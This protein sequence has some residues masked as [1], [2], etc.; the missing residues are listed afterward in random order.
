MKPHV[1]RRLLVVAFGLS[2]LAVGVGAG[3][4]VTYMGGRDFANVNT[5]ADFGS[6]VSFAAT[7][8]MVLA[9]SAAR[10]AGR[11]VAHSAIGVLRQLVGWRRRRDHVGHGAGSGWA[12]HP[13]VQRWTYRCLKIVGV[14]LPVDQRHVWAAEVAANLASAETGCEWTRVLLSEFGELPGNAWVFRR[15]R[16]RKPVR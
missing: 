16:L 7:V 12:K 3:V 9:N 2:F 4:I 5:L 13:N 1:Q 8:I 10:L 11:R 14:V 6:F 15:D